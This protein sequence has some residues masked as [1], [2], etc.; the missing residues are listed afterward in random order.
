MS[1]EPTNESEK[2][3]LAP[4]EREVRRGIRPWKKCAVCGGD[5]YSR[6]PGEFMRHGKGWFDCEYG[7]GFY[8]RGFNEVPKPTLTIHYPDGA[9]STVT[10]APMWQP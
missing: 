1:D 9:E 10:P 6:D 3:R 7:H 2:S 5:A 8:S 4:V